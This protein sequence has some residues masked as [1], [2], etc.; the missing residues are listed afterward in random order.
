MT[1]GFSM[2]TSGAGLAIVLD[3]FLLTR[4]SVV[5]EYKTCCFVLTRVT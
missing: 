5:P 1:L 3:I 2:H 4:P